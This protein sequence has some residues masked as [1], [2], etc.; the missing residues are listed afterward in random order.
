MRYWIDRR[1]RELSLRFMY[2]LDVKSEDF[3]YDFDATKI[4]L[5]TNISRNTINKIIWKIRKKI[6]LS[7]M[8]EE[9]FSGEFESDESYFGAKRIRGKYFVISPIKDRNWYNA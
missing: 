2:S 3:S 7:L 6:F 4:A 9:K 8:K 5:L 1:A